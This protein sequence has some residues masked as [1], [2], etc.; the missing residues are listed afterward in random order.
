MILDT[1]TNLSS[2]YL[3]ER[4]NLTLTTA[5]RDAD[6]LR[7]EVNSLNYGKFGRRY[8]NRT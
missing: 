8:A 2:E 7:T 6:S 1:N 4:R 5:S 3:T